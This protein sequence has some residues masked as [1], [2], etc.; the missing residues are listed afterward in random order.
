MPDKPEN[1]AFKLLSSR[2]TLAHERCCGGLSD[3]NTFAEKLSA[4]CPQRR[5]INRSQGD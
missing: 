5:P 2:K 4:P 1:S 3:G